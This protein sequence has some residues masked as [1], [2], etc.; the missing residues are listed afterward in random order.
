MPVQ[1]LKITAHKENWLPPDAQSTRGVEALVEIGR[2]GLANEILVV[3]EAP[4]GDTFF[5][6]AGWAQA[7]DIY[8]RLAVIEDTESLIALPRA[9]SAKLT[10]ESLQNIPRRTLDPLLSP[11][12]RTMLFRVIPDSD[13]DFDGLERLV[14]RIRAV[15]PGGAAGEPAPV[16]SVG[17]LPASMVD[18]VAIAWGWMPYVIGLVILGAFL[19]LT[20]AFRAPVVA[21]KAV[22]LNLFSVSAA[23]GL[24]TLVFLDGHGA[25][26]V[27][28]EGPVDGVFPAMPLIVFCAVFGVSMDYEVFLISRIAAAQR[29]EPGETAA[30]VRGISETGMVITVAAAIMIVVFGSFAATGFLPAKMLGFTLATAVFLDAA[31][32]RITMS[33]ALMRLAGRWNWWPGM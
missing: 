5:S 25:W 30:I 20:A 17:G 4:E 1:G 14:G 2:R 33:P 12:N 22:L 15:E 3:A 27:G 10:P 7:Y 16:L 19:V 11:D 32:V 9:M 29:V 18:Y 24:A 31:V 28:A 26:L 6:A 8:A 13:L 21:A 23:F